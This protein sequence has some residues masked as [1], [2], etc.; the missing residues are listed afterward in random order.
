MRDVPCVGARPARG[1]VNGVPGTLIAPAAG[2]LEAGSLRLVVHGSGPSAV[3]KTTTVPHTE[4]V[5]VPP[6]AN[7]E[8]VPW[9]TYATTSGDLHVQLSTYEAGG[10]VFAL[11]RHR[12]P[13][14]AARP[15]PGGDIRVFAG[16]RAADVWGDAPAAMLAT[17]VDGCTCECS[18]GTVRFVAGL[19]NM[20]VLEARDAQRSM[21]VLDLIDAVDRPPSTRS[22]DES[23]QDVPHGAKL[24]SGLF[25]GMCTAPVPGHA[26]VGVVMNL[27]SGGRRK[28]LVADMQW[29][30]TA[31]AAGGAWQ[32]CIAAVDG[33]H[34]T[35]SSAGAATFEPAPGVGGVPPYVGTD[36]EQEDMHV[37]VLAVDA[38]RVVWLE[39]DEDHRVVAVLTAAADND[40]PRP[41]PSGQLND[42]GAGATVSITRAGSGLSVSVSAG[43]ANTAATPATDASATS[44]AV[45]GVQGKFY[46]SLAP[47]RSRV[48]LVC[49]RG[50]GGAPKPLAF[51]AAAAAR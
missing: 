12:K 27:R 44:F 15:P 40:R 4:Y 28:E 29:W 10:L 49:P 21:V 20:V 43:G 33:A 39:N 18:A 45:P 37:I 35:R 38:N 13:A 48:V 34:V 14:Q 11:Q 9:G 31:S 41:L 46:A 1:I 17:A 2:A 16:A 5:R 51:Q 24:R 8:W 32:R 26:G 6:L 36:G 19:R 30:S 25:R 3:L 47:A 22:I 23:K 7:P 50:T 42:A